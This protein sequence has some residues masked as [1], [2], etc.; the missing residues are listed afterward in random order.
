MVLSAVAHV[1]ITLNAIASVTRERRTHA[2]QTM[3]VRSNQG[4]KLEFNVCSA[5]VKR[6]NR[7]IIS[8]IYVY[9]HLSMF[10]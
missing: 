7:I 9:I 1:C 5:I 2:A 6:P 3:Y 4:L 10:V 8:L